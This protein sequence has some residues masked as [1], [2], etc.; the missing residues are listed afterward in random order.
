MMLVSKVL[1]LLCLAGSVPEPF[2]RGPLQAHC[3]LWHPLLANAVS[4]LIHNACLS[5]HPPQPG[6]SAEGK[7][8]L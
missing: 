4:A 7:V 2:I 3:A 6:P 1:A 8:C 5:P